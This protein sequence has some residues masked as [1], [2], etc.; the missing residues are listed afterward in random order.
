MVLLVALTYFILLINYCVAT[1]FNCSETNECANS[2]FICENDEDC[3]IYCSGYLSCYNTSF[4]CP[5]STNN[6]ENLSCKAECSSDDPISGNYISHQCHFTNFNAYNTSSFSLEI[7]GNDRDTMDALISNQI[8]ITCPYDG[9]CDI[10]CGYSDIF[11]TYYGCYNMYI[12]AILSEINITSNGIASF[13]NMIINAA[14]AKQLTMTGQGKAA[15]TNTS[16]WCPNDDNM[17]FEE[18]KVCNIIFIPDISQNVTDGFYLTQIYSIDAFRSID[19]NCQPFSY[20]GCWGDDIN[21]SQQAP[22]IYCTND[23]SES[24]LATSTDGDIWTCVDR[25]SRCAETFITTPSPIIITTTPSPTTRF[26]IKLDSAGIITIVFMSILGFITVTLVI[27]YWCHRMCLVK[28]T[29][30]QLKWVNKEI[31]EPI[32]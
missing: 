13:M 17:D 1:I 15:Y 8:S 24:C 20:I 10:N 30:N 14:E 26:D 28:K 2:T 27:F 16:I 9:S 18:N 29:R 6:D 23:Y 25:T 11:K 32:D 31:Y 4:I 22:M 21:I 19:I 5:K 12:D 7:I 3:S